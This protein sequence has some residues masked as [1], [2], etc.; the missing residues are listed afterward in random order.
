VRTL[1]VCAIFAF[2]I[3]AFAH[4]KQMQSTQRSTA[5]LALPVAQAMARY[6][7]A[8]LV[9]KSENMALTGTLSPSVSDL[10]NP[11]I[12]KSCADA[13]SVATIL[14]L[15]RQANTAGVLTALTKITEGAPGIGF[16]SSNQVS[17]L[18]T[19]TALPCTATDGSVVMLTKMQ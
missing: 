15:P 5:S 13:S 8:A 19:M 14:L 1:L 7:N 11:A 6:H 4:N 17:V 10:S 12:W 16:A 3:G 18:G 9:L 2:L